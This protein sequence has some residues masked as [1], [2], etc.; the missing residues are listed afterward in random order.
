MNLLDEFDGQEQ[1][2]DECTC[3]E[4]KGSGIVEA[5]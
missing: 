4:G 5:K 2:T 1:I 3:F